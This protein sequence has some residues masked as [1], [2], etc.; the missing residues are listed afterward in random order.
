MSF[1]FLNFTQ[2]TTRLVAEQL[3][4]ALQCDNQLSVRYLME[5]VVVIVLSRYPKLLDDFFYPH[6][7]HVSLQ[8]QA[9][10]FL[11]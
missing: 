8:S 3:L 9:C 2:G 10:T 7:H 11:S 6:L 5:W 1:L 4:Q